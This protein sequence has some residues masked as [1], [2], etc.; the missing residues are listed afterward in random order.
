MV[1]ASS[2]NPYKIIDF[3]WAINAFIGYKEFMQG[4]IG[5]MLNDLY[6]AFQRS[7]DE[8]ISGTKYNSISISIG[9]V[10]N[11]DDK[12]MY[13]AFVNWSEYSQKLFLEVLDMRIEENDQR[14]V[15]QFYIPC[16]SVPDK[17]VFFKYVAKLVEALKLLIK[18]EKSVDI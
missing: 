11:T 17:A 15:Y 12:S 18:Q 3:E 7:E 4:D 8:S 13:L 2:E 16:K 14:K 9:D 6:I 1:K 5:V 10:D